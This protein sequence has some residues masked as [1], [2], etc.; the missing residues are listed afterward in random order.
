MPGLGGKY[1]NLKSVLMK[2]LRMVDPLLVG[3]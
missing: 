3:V 1:D 2:G